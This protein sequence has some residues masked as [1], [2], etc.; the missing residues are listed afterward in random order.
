ML[1]N[2][3]I[4][5]FRSINEMVELSMIPSDLKN[6]VN[7]IIKTNPNAT[8]NKDYYALTSAAIYGPNASGKSNVIRALREFADYIKSSTDNKPDDPILLFNPFKLNNS[9]IKKPSLFS[10]DMLID[11]VLY[12]YSIEVTY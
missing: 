5:N 10:I 2:F 7:R 6:P 12:T 1:L 3:R 11:N 8:K 4:A 9:N